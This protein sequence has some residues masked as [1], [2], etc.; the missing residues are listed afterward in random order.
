MSGESRAPSAVAIVMKDHRQARRTV[1][2]RIEG[3]VQGVFYRAWTEETARSLALSGWVR[4]RTDGSV[5]AV[6]SGPAESV[7]A[8]LEA[9]RQGPPAA[10]VRAVRIL[11]EAAEPPPGFAV[12]PTA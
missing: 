7:Q 8:M 9:C 1:L 10:R 11:E 2:V 6:F 12:R 4:N 3:Q 5:E